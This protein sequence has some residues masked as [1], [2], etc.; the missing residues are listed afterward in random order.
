[1]TEHSPDFQAE[2][3]TAEVGN[4]TLGGP[5]F[6]AKHDSYKSQDLQQGSISQA[7]GN[8]QEVTKGL[9]LAQALL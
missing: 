5:R 7:R 1:V 2:Q 9:L 3:R 4:D 6:V 8:A